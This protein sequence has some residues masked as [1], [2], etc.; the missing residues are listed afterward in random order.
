MLPDDTRVFVE[1]I[2]EIYIMNNLKAEILIEVD[3]LISKRINIDFVSQSIFI[4]N[5][6]EL[7][8]S[9]NFRARSK[10]IKRIIKLSV[11]TIVLSRII[12]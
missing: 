12:I 9:I 10:L 5:Y 6:R 4:D 7:I 2:R 11:K 3:I 1:I 8:V